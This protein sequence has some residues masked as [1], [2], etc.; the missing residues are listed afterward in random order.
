MISIFFFFGSTHINS[1]IQGKSRESHHNH[2]KKVRS[3]IHYFN[4]VHLFQNHTIQCRTLIPKITY[5]VILV[6]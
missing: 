4:T 6:Q 1:S 5:Y 2:S 3:I